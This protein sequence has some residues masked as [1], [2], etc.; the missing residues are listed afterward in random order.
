[1]DISEIA[2]EI[3]QRYGYPQADADFEPY[4]DFKVRW[5]RSGGGH[6]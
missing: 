6:R 4:A 5:E 3:A 1:M 2:N